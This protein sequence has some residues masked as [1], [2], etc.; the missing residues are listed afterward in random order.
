M[1]FQQFSD[2]GVVLSRTQIQTIT[3]GYDICP[4]DQCQSDSQC[5]ASGSQC[6]PY[7]CEDNKTSNLCTPGDGQA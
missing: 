6:A 2:L 3:G 1:N 5:P 4:R 7:T